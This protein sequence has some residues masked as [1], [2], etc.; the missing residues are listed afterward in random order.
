MTTRYQ[1]FET[2]IIWYQVVIKLFTKKYYLSPWAQ[3][4]PKFDFKIT[5]F[6]SKHQLSGVGTFTFSNR[7]IIGLDTGSLVLI[8][9][10]HNH[11]LAITIP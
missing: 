6:S 11:S 4:K 7:H 10:D 1:I 3:V 8:V 9:F 5:Y 2:L